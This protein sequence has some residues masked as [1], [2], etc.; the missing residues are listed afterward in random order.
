MGIQDNDRRLRVQYPNAIYHLMSRGVQR[1]NIFLN[2][3]DRR[4]FFDRCEETVNRFLW[5][6]YCAVQMS[7]HFHLLFQTPQPNLCQGAQYLWGPYAQGFNRRHKRSG[8]VFEARY[9]CRVIEDESYLWGVSRYDHLNPVPH[10]VKHPSQWE[11]SSYPGY[12]N[13][14]FR[15]PWALALR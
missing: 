15:L 14:E 6:V 9:R 11:W 5:R 13:N 3:V 12:V 10:L 8:H 2:D 7:N 4:A 1:S